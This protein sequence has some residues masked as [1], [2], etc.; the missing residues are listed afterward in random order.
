M[1]FQYKLDLM[2]NIAQVFIIFIDISVDVLELGVICLYN[3]SI[4]SILNK[5]RIFQRKANRKSISKTSIFSFGNV[6]IS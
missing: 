4:I 2:P 3:V 6:L 1:C 5:V